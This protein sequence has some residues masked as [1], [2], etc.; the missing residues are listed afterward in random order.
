MYQTAT[1]QQW[2]PNTQPITRRSIFSRS[3]D[4][5]DIPFEDET[6]PPA[7]DQEPARKT[8]ITGSER[9]AFE[10]LYRTVNA[11]GR[12]KN[13]KD[14]AVELDQVADEYYEEE[15]EPSKSLDQVFDEVLKGGSRLRASRTIVQ[16]T[17]PAHEQPEEKIPTAKKKSGKTLWEQEDSLAAKLRIKDLKTVQMEKFHSILQNARTD[18]ELWQILDREVFEPVRKLNLDG[19]EA[20]KEQEQRPKP[21]ANAKR[22]LSVSDQRVLFQNYPH[23]LNT[24]V[25]TLRTDFPASPL[26]LS[27]LPT[28]KALGRSSYALGATTTLYKSLIRTA[29]IQQSSYTYINTLL[30]DMN[31]GAIEF[32]RD[33]LALLDSIIKEHDLARSARL[34]R[35]MQMVYSMEQF[36]DGIRKIMEWRDVVAEKLGVAVDER[37]AAGKVVRRFDVDKRRPVDP[38]NYTGP[39]HIAFSPRA[40]VKPSRPWGRG[41]DDPL[42]EGITRPEA[43]VDAVPS[44]VSEVAEKEGLGDADVVS[45]R[46][47]NDTEGP[48]KLML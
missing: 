12:P 42:I 47:Q 15:E 22:E 7:I 41:D 9:A 14:H 31:N 28:I 29:W 1:I 36:Q 5:D 43:D 26:P 48:A 46:E 45:E 40:A 20:T 13:D 39:R 3:R 23:Y 2:R 27:I 34:G 11:Q 21:K 38:D 33:I 37:K 17:R 18:R 19:T 24:A 8:T 30:T 32:D 25:H 6:L 35:E 44:A 4:G 10:K 16:R